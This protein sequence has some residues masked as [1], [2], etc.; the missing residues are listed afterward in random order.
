MHTRHKH[1]QK[2]RCRLFTALLSEPLVIIIVWMWHTLCMY[3]CMH[4]CTVLYTAYCMEYG[5]FYTL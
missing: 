1:F 2:V 4:A 5:T 3:V